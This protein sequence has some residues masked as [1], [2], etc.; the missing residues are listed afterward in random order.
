MPPDSDRRDQLAVDRTL[1]ANE[2][3]LLAYVRTA[4]ALLGAGVG[5]LEFVD[6]TAASFAGWTCAVAG[7]LMV[8]LGLWRYLTVRARLR[9]GQSGIP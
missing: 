5:L 4:L 8:P 6:A 7:A 2:R 9:D 3:T 1:L